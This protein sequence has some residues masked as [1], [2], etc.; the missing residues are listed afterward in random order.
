MT[1][2]YE[3][4]ALQALSY[5]SGD[6]S[7]CCARALHKMAP[8]F[9]KRALCKSVGICYRLMLSAKLREYCSQGRPRRLGTWET[10]GT[11]R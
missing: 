4:S 1:D 10:L 3:I 7:T 5:E 11:Q 6:D 2:S 9:L 8:K